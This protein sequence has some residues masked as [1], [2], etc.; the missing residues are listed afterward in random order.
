MTNTGA[1]NLAF[2]L[3]QKQIGNALKDIE[4][5]A[6]A[7]LNISGVPKIDID[8]IALDAQ[9]IDWTLLAGTKS[10]RA[11][12]E[13]TRNVWDELKSLK[14]PVTLTINVNV[15]TKVKGSK[16]GVLPSGQKGTVKAGPIAVL[17]T[18]N[19]IIT[20]KNLYILETSPTSTPWKINVVFG[21][22]RHLW[23]ERL[24]SREFNHHRKTNKMQEVKFQ[25]GD[26]TNAANTT[27]FDE[28][29]YAPW[30]LKEKGSY[31]FANSEKLNSK[32]A[33]KW[34]AMAVVRNILQDEL[35]LHKGAGI[36][37]YTFDEEG[38]FDNGHE[39]ENL[40]WEM[41]SLTSSLGQ[42][43]NVARANIY[44]HPDGHIVIYNLDRDFTVN[45]I[46]QD[47][48]PMENS[49]WPEAQDLSR[50]RPGFVTTL[51]PV[52]REIKFTYAEDSVGSSIA[53]N[54]L[55][56]SLENVVQL[57]DSLKVKIDGVDKT[58]T[59]GS[60]V[61]LEEAMIAWNADT[62]HPWSENQKLYIN[63]LKEYW[64]ADRL[65]FKFAATRQNTDTFNDPILVNRVGAIMRSY[66]QIFRIRKEWM[67]KIRSWEPLRS[68]VIDP[69][70]GV[71]QPSPVF[72][73][74]CV[75]PSFRMPIWKKGKK[76]HLAAYNVNGYS[77]KV[78]TANPSPFLI[79]Q[80]SNPLGIF[81]ISFQ[82]D[83]LSLTEESIPSH[84]FNIPKLSAGA[85]T[86]S[87]FWYKSQLS[88]THNM[89]TIISCT[90]AEPNDFGRHLELDYTFD[91][92]DPRKTAHIPISMETA[93][94]RW[95][96]KTAGYIQNN[97]IVVDGDVLENEEII[98]S[99]SQAEV[100]RYKKSWENVII[101]MFRQPG[102]KESW[103]PSGSMK[104]VTIS[105]SATSGLSTLFNMTERATPLNLFEMLPL[106]VRRVIYKQLDKE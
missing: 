68:A 17:E 27:R 73:N 42:I 23:E 49:G 12:I 70:S 89:S 14:N 87:K 39:V 38:E 69:I 77:T 47:F 62:T 46:M 2:D 35:G 99:I 63:R 40:R 29:A 10:T 67:D 92:G 33:E 58:Y 53:P 6:N 76:D 75:V 56:F 74:Y 90:L 83:A 9:S 43:L 71:R 94:Y 34:T 25:K 59:K 7:G 91:G 72:M 93:R 105:F 86:S 96:D 54:K 19:K 104:S 30:S 81:S 97:K 66:R 28:F 20:I 102:Y 82:N 55:A 84:V 36:G 4:Q 32:N 18:V 3:A 44:Q 15:A 57:P 1:L 65:K 11:N 95:T 51:H 64:F 85:A 13:V 61:P 24:I 60:W 80:I 100:R 5:A 48:Q 52:T 8:G 101:G 50:V 31:I 88:S 16:G 79:T 103:L 21:D 45:T 106:S 26:I 98:K 22:Q 37:G 41:S 78:D